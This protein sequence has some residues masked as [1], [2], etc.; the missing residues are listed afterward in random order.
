MVK[1]LQL[2]VER[3]PTG[4]ENWVNDNPMD[5]KKISLSWFR[6]DNFVNLSE[7]RKKNVIRREVRKLDESE[8]SI[9]FNKKEDFIVT[10]QGRHDFKNPRFKGEVQIMKDNIL[11][12]KNG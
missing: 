5:T 3:E 9:D 6:Q 4:D 11:V 7:K 10:E 12:D 1:K 8:L 2:L